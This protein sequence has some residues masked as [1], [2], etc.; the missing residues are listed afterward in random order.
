MPFVSEA[1]R[2]YFMANRKKLERQGVNVD[3]W[4]RASKKVLPMHHHKKKQK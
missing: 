1:Q 3:E 4:Q 2:R